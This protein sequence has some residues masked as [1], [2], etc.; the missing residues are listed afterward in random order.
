MGV[1][2]WPVVKR[3]GRVAGGPATAQQWFLL[4]D[5]QSATGWLLWSHRMASP[6]GAL[7]GSAFASHAGSLGV[8]LSPSAI[9]R[10]ESGTGKGWASAIVGYE[11][12]LGLPPATLL[13][14]LRAAAR[15][16]PDAPE[17][18]ALLEHARLPEDPSV[19]DECYDTYLAGGRLAGHR[20]IQLA[21]QLTAAPTTHLP[22][23]LLRQWVFCLIDEYM[24]SVNHAYYCR[25]E[26]ASMLA[27]HPLTSPVVLD[28]VTTLASAPGASGT[29]DAW[30]LL[31]DVT[32]LA[33]ITS[34]VDRLPACDDEQ[35]GGF[36]FALW[37]HSHLGLLPR[38]LN[39]LLAD[40][41]IERTAAWTLGSLEPIAV[42]AAS[43]PVRHRDRVLAAVD[44]IHPMARMTGGRQTRR[45]DAELEFYLQVASQA[46]W[47]G[48]AD[49]VL[50]E[51]LRVVLSA[52][53]PGVQFHATNL[54]QVSPYA[55][56]L[57]D[58]ALRL[59]D[60]PDA[61]AETA[62]L[63]SFVVSRL[64][65]PDNVAAI[66]ALVDRPEPH[67]VGI[68]LV[69]LAHLHYDVAE[70]RLQALAADPTTASLAVYYA[71][72]LQHPLLRSGA[73]PG[74]GA[75]W[76]RDHPGGCWD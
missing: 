56:A 45:V 26:A 8:A 40:V 63:A 16:Q 11:V 73:M 57:T 17:S 66:A 4:D 32:D 14:P 70:E 55:A 2:T 59:I 1:V 60:A 31:G 72:M 68:A 30:G 54:L 3:S 48:H 65:A 5:L 12:A 46:T 47:P 62:Q 61:S 41:L 19:V 20:W 28:A 6:F 23:K 58:A 9:S 42:L 25:M 44:A 64:A 74:A 38:H 15:L 50:R 49:T 75:A 71:G 7:T 52:T 69:A 22:R 10:A 37:Q 76:W 67:L 21:Q 51:M 35:F 33:T 27:A 43:L 18:V 24:R 36:C 53:S 34:I 13:A 39:A 29:H